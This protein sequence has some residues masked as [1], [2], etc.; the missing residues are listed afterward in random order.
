MYVY[1][2]KRWLI[3]TTAWLEIRITKF[4]EQ[5]WVGKEKTNGF[6]KDHLT[7]SLPKKEKLIDFEPQHFLKAFL[8]LK[9]LKNVLKVKK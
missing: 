1:I 8:A 6:N 9:I 4:K 2:Y 5:Y 3:Y 7:P